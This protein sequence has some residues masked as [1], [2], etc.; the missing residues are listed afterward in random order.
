MKTEE[1]EFDLM[2]SQTD[3]ARYL[4]AARRSDL[5]FLV[6]ASEAVRAWERR[7]PD[8]W[9]RFSCWLTAQGKEIVEV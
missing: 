9:A 3:L 6:V 8:I 4:E 7:E 2:S 5:P 1:L